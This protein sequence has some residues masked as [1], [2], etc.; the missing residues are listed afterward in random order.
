MEGTEHDLRKNHP[1]ERN[2]LG[3]T[4]VEGGPCSSCHLFHRCARQLNPTEID[5]VGQCTS[6]HQVGQCAQA[7]LPGSVNHPTLKCTECHNPHEPRFGH[8]LRG[9]PEDVCSMCH[10]DKTRLVAGPHD[11]HDND[12]AWCNESNVITDR[13]M[14]CHRPHGDEKTGLFRVAPVTANGVGVDGSCLAC[15]PKA[16]WGG[17]TPISAGH[18]QTGA[19]L[20]NTSLPLV[21]TDHDAAMRVGCRTCH[22]PHSGKDKAFLLRSG[23]G[24]P[25]TL[26]TTC[27]TEMQQIV[28]TTHSEPYLSA[29]GL[30][31]GECRPCHQVHA[32]KQSIEPRLMF[33]VSVAG[34]AGQTPGVADDRY[35]IGCHRDGG[36]APVPA[37]YT[38]PIVPMM[39]PPTG[40]GGS[41]LRL[42]DVEGM[43]DAKGRI[44]CRTCHTPHGREAINLTSVFSER[45]HDLGEE[46]LRSMQLLIRTF[47]PPNLCSTCHGQDAWR[48]FLYFHDPERR[49]GPLSLPAAVRSN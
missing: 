29:K 15:H 12:A 33:P 11:A 22:N 47:E 5:P 4:P 25:E 19:L 44:T 10:T 46:A 20:T 8:F 36:A 45:G 42:F 39:E 26:C 23:D 38:H 35:C 9:K 14:A 16:A 41:G 24:L 6:C 3:M 30:T 7:K 17:D 13:C 18:P 1:D 28:H 43:P 2:R 32:A 40:I 37:I 27:H 21:A 31:A 49:R 34:V 48:R